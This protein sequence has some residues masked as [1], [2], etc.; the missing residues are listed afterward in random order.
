MNSP[1]S[2]TERLASGGNLTIDEFAAW[3]GLG[4]VT[5]YSEIANGRLALTKIGK[6]SR[7]AAPD[8][9]AWRD[10][11]RNESKAREIA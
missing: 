11:R 8:A 10:A 6:S 1:L 3:A 2:V 4:R 7:I 9:V 5:V